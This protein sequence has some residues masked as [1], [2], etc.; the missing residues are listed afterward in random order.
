METIMTSPTIH[1]PIQPTYL[2]IKQHS[3]TGLKYFGKTTHPDPIKYLGSGTR[4]VRHITKHGK[5]FV[6]TIW[7][8]DV[9]YDTSIRE[10]ALHFSC[11]N[12]IDTTPSVW[13]NLIPED[14]L[15]G[16]ISGIPRSAETKRK[17]S[18]ST[19]GRIQSKEWIEKGA[20]A[21]TGLT[22]SDETKSKMSTAASG[23]QITEEHKI[24][25]STAL[26]G[27]PH[28]KVA[29]PHCPKIGGVSAMTKHHFENCKFKPSPDEFSF[30]P[31]SSVI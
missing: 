8:S 7:L 24:K 4:W 1:L 15:T 30:S 12:K 25:I 9:Y 13:A 17:M 14:G 10:P 22:R 29:C 21:R 20:K 28:R 23:K 18:A 26:K 5:Q 2:Y 6:E 3:V 11:E 19:K 16:V 31:C 27:V